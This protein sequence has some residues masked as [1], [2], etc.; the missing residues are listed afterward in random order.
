M[1]HDPLE[2]AVIE[3]WIVLPSSV[4]EMLVSLT[5]KPLPRMVIV[6]PA[7]TEEGSTEI[8]AGTVNAVSPT[9]LVVVIL[10]RALMLWVPAVASGVLKVVVN[11][12]F[13]STVGLVMV[14]PSQVTATPDSLARKEVP[15]TVTEVPTLPEVT[16]SEIPGETVMVWVVYE[17]ADVVGPLATM[18]SAPP[19]EAGI[20]NDELQ[21]P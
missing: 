16:L 12:P 5:L 2:L 8:P 13:A 21:E 15:V 1:L 20:T 18:L 19:G 17:L 3:L 11:P 9:S 6:S 14:V 7:L 10:P 4:T